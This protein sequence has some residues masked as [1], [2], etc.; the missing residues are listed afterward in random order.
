VTNAKTLTF[1]EPGMWRA[2]MAGVI[3][4]LPVIFCSSF[5]LSVPSVHP[6]TRL[7]PD[8]DTKLRQYLVLYNA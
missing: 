1:L 4:L 8:S 5:F 2:R 7:F 3:L 6:P